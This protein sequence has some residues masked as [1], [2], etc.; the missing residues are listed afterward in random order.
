MRAW[1]SVFPRAI[2]FLRWCGDPKRQEGRQ[3]E[4]NIARLSGLSLS[5]YY[6]RE[7][8][9]GLVRVGEGACSTVQNGL[10]GTF[11]AIAFRLV[12]LSCTSEWFESGEGTK[13]ARKGHK[14]VCPMR[15][16]RIYAAAEAL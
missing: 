12:P 6:V 3:S 7:L 9:L 14:I 10:V 2:E 1:S 15:F 8:P 11:T 16:I 5:N 4:W 13:W